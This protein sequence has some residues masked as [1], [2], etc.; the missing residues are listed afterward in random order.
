MFKFVPYIGKNRDELAD[1]IPYEREIEGR[2]RRPYIPD[3]FFAEGMSIGSVYTSDVNL[4]WSP[5]VRGSGA[6]VG[7]PFS[8]IDAT[9]TW[10][11][12][13]EIEV[14]VSSP[15]VRT[16]TEI[17]DDEWIYTSAMNISDN[18]SLASEVIF[19]I[20]NYRYSENV[21]YDSPQAE[22]TVMKVT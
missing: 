21:R 20:T 10:E 5:R 17:N 6:G 1:A 16:T 14:Y 15:L 7:D 3:N 9:P 22:V 12:Y 13:F 11:G 4:T 8:T 18:G 2:S 19:K